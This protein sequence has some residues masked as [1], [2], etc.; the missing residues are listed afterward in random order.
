MRPVQERCWC[1]QYGRC[2]T[3]CPTADLPPP[4]PMT[5][6]NWRRAWDELRSLAVQGEPQ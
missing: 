4:R 2:L 1:W 5:D 6:A 3:D